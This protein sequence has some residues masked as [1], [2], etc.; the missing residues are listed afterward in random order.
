M[1]SEDV[2]RTGG[3]RWWLPPGAPPAPA[4]AAILAALEARARGSSPNLKPGKRKQLYA[5]R[6]APGSGVPDHLLKANTYRM[7]RGFL[8]LFRPSKS[9][10]ELLTA[11]RLASRGLPAPIPL[12]AGEERRFGRLVACY[13]LIPVLPDVTDLRRLW[14]E[15]PLPP[16]RRRALTTAFGAFSRRVHAGGFFQDDYAPNNILVKSGTSP[17]FLLIDFERARLVP[18]VRRARKRWM[19]AKLSRHMDDATAAECLRFLLA[20]AGGDRREARGWWRDVAD[21]APRLA[22]RD[23]RRARRNCTADGRN[24]TRVRRPDWTGF[25]RR[26]TD[27]VPILAESP[28]TE[29]PPPAGRRRIAAAPRCWRVAYGAISAREGREIWARA[30]TLWASG[31]L[32]PRPLAMLWRA[33]AAT[34]FLAREEGARRLPDALNAAEARRATRVLFARLGALG[35][36]D[37][38]LGPE[39]VLL[40]PV[41]RWPLRAVL[42]APDAV[43]FR[44]ARKAPAAMRA[45]A[46]RLFSA[47]A[48]ASSRVS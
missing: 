42:L 23:H 2:I 36:V 37:A 26:D 35:E 31:K 40:G 5:L 44:G 6:L 45:I 25:A 41:G 29:R 7:A 12:A 13:L 17:S 32:V 14:F 1:R 20:Y 19:L 9:R 48:A 16:A 43:A 33:G 4:S 18:R 24:F 47:P 8:R 3:I 28:A 30:N 39:D 10:R 27:L 34:L 11:I 38:A 21:F 15:A 22:R 46:D